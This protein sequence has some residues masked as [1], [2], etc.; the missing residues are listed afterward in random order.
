MQQK[1]NPQLP[2]T[3]YVEKLP[4]NTF[5]LISFI[6]QIKSY[7]IGMLERNCKIFM[8]FVERFIKYIMVNTKSD[9]NSSSYPS[10]ST[11]IEFAK[12]L[13]T[14]LKELGIKDVEMD[15]YG[16]IYGGIS[17]D[18]NKDIIG[19]IAHMDTSPEIDGGNFKPR[20][21]ENYDGNPIKLNDK[22]VLNSEEFPSL[23]DHKGQS[24]IVTDG[25]HLLGGDDKAGI[26]IIFEIL[27]YYNSHPEIK[28]APIRFC[29]TPDEEIGN[30]ADHFDVKKMKAKIAYTIDG[31]KYNEVNYENFN[32]YSVKVDV[33][34]RGVHPGSAKNIMINSI[35]LAM[36][37][38]SLLP[39]NMVPEKTE[40]YEGFNH[41]SDIKGSVEHT[42]LNYIIRNHDSGQIAKQLEDFNNIKESLNKKYPHAK[43]EVTIKESYRNMYDY[44]KND[45]TAIHKLERAFEKVNEKIIF[46]PIRGGTDG[47][48][49][50]F[51]GLPC[52]NIGT[53]DY[54]CHGRY[55]Y[56]SIDEMAKVI[57]IV[58]ALL[59]E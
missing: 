49:I 31:G 8:N 55:E 22:Y 27:K 41:L 14:D 5:L 35:T 39:S 47:A 10:T 59:E 30:G 48:R 40:G 54:N 11:Q 32:A 17:G 19:L 23:L 33:Y 45:M 43:I 53:G 38:N 50:T 57:S 13:L 46:S 36:E 25:E 52:P 9:E 44:F 51:M 16:L 1:F 20:I 34:G 2:H 56:V 37:F 6:Y 15:Q 3:F 28:H 7:T 4:L 42:E 18:N 26:A 21:I 29:F 24:L 12:M 58:K